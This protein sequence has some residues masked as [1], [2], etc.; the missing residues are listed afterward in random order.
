[1]SPLRKVDKFVNLFIIKELLY[2][3][4]F[5]SNQCLVKWALQTVYFD[6]LYDNLTSLIKTN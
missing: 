6:T 2:K 4:A 3:D 5:L 1:M